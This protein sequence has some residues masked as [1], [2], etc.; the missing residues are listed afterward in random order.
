MNESGQT[1][2]GG[3]SEQSNLLPL[4][5]ILLSAIVPNLRQVYRSVLQERMAH[6]ATMQLIQRIKRGEVDIQSVMITDDGWQLLPAR[7]KPPETSLPADSVKRIDDR[8]VNQT[9]DNLKKEG[10][11]GKRTDA[12]PSTS[13]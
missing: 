8:I 6:G 2:T 4:D 5:E 13:R 3:Y 12:I 9:A 1:E 10:T 7:P 11:D